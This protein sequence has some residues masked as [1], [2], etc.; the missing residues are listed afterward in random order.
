MKKIVT[1]VYCPVGW[2]FLVTIFKL[3]EYVKVI[4]DIDKIYLKQK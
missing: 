4:K 1:I 2:D 3:F